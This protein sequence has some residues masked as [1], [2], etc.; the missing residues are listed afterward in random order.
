M[1]IE[2]RKDQTY[3]VDNASDLEGL[4]LAADN[5][6]LTAVNKTTGDVSFVSNIDGEGAVAVGLKKAAILEYDFD[7]DGGA[8]G[9]I[10]LRGGSLPAGAIVTKTQYIVQTALSS[11]GAAEIA[12]SI[13]VDDVAGL[14]A[15]TA[16]ATAG[17]AGV[18]DGIQDGTAANASE[19]ATESRVPTLDVSVADLDA[20]KLQ[21]VLEYLN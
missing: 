8:Q 17:T 12:L 20:G 6:V 5:H 10:P 3:A 16:I 7:I 4:A 11:A 2:K 9:S 21:V 18:K 13:P 1:A 14:L 15:A 19:A